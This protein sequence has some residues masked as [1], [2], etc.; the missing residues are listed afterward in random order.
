MKRCH[1]SPL[2]SS[3]PVHHTMC[4]VSS[5]NPC[6][7]FSGH[8]SSSTGLSKTNFLLPVVLQFLLNFTIISI[9]YLE[10]PTLGIF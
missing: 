7:H 4:L 3:Q 8:W 9:K 2:L 5:S 6:N 1:I 10:I